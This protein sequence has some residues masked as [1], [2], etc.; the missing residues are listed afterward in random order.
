MYSIGGPQTPHMQQQQMQQGSGAHDVFAHQAPYSEDYKGYP[1]Q[2]GSLP[3]S[4][5]RYTTS[6]GQPGQINPGEYRPTSDAVKACMSGP[7]APL[8]IDPVLANASALGYHDQNGLNSASGHSY[9][10]VSPTHAN[11]QPS[12]TN[13]S[14]TRTNGYNSVS[15][16]SSAAPNHY[17]DPSEPISP[18]PAFDHGTYA[19]MISYS[20]SADGSLAD[21]SQGQHGQQM[22]PPPMFKGQASLDPHMQ[23]M[24]QAHHAHGQGMDGQLSHSRQ[25]SAD[26]RVMYPTMA[27][28]H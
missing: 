17:Y 16:P 1:S 27:R 15:G 22:P 9:S 19:P 14:P 4:P 26:L 23:D 21:V 12:T 25:T 7:S 2:N 8:S 24:S 28:Q 20:H 11:Q 5:T 10:T 18:T 3:E 6:Y 13:T